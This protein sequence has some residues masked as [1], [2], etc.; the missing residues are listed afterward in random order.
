M[1][2]MRVEPKN[3]GSVIWPNTGSDKVMVSFA[4]VPMARFD[5][6]TVILGSGTVCTLVMTVLPMMNPDVSVRMPFLVMMRPFGSSPGSVIIA[7]LSAMAPGNV[8]LY[9]TPDIR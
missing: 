9:G 1:N 8:K 2:M 4:F 5:I 7:E 3:P 6:V